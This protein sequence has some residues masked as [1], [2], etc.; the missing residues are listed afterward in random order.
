MSSVEKNVKIVEQV[1][2]VS[3]TLTEEQANRLVS[4]FGYCTPASGFSNLYND[5]R[6]A[7]YSGKGY[8]TTAT[9]HSVV[10]ESHASKW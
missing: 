9:G 1:E 10:V 5:L 7:G 3:L 4:L 6:D 8:K 2:S